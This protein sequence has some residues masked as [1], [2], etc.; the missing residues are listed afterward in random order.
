M[1]AQLCRPLDTYHGGPAFHFGIS[2]D[3][4]ALSFAAVFQLFPQRHIHGFL[5][6]GRRFRLDAPGIRKRE[7]FLQDN[8]TVAHVR[9]F[10]PGLST[11]AE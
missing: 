2:Q 10:F 4:G 9:H 5:H 8:I 1:P 3:N 11:I 7:P 6:H